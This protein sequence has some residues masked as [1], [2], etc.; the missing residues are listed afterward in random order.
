MNVEFD[1]RSNIKLANSELTVDQTICAPIEGISV[2]ST[3]E[4]TG[5]TSFV[6]EAGICATIPYTEPVVSFAKG[7]QEGQD[8]KEYFR[9]PRLVSSG[10]CSAS[11][12]TLYN[13]NVDRPFLF[14]T[15]FPNGLI[16]L[17]GVAGVRFNLVATVTVAANPFH[18]GL[19][20][21]AF[22]HDGKN[23]DTYQYCRLLSPVL[24]TNLPHVRLDIAE[25]T[26]TQLTVPWLYPEDYMPLTGPEVTELGVF[27]I[28]QVIPTPTLASSPAPTWRLYF[29]LEDLELIG[30]R[31]Q[32]EQLIVAQG[33]SRIQKPSGPKTAIQELKETGLI[34]KTLAGA[35]NVASFVSRHVPMLSTVGGMTSWALSY[36]S[37]AAAAWGFSKPRDRN[38]PIRHFTTDYVGEGNHDIP[39]QAFTISATA[40]NALRIDSTMGGTEVDEMALSHILPRWAQIALT[41]ITTTDTIGTFLYSSNTCLNHY[42]FRTGTTKPFS[43]IAPPFNS[44]TTNCFLPSP[45][46]FFGNFFRMWRGGL[47][48]RFTFGKSKFHAGRVMVGF[49][50]LARIA[51]ADTKNLD[52]VSAIEVT[53]GL[54]QPFSYTKI[55]DLK[56]G[57]S[58]EFEIPYLSP[59]LWTSM[60]GYTGGVTMVVVDTLIA[61]GECATNIP[62]LVE[63][64][65][66]EDFEFAVPR[67]HTMYPVTGNT[68]LTIYTQSGLSVQNTD[69]KEYTVGEAIPSLKQLLMIPTNTNFGLGGGVTWVTN[70]PFFNYYPSFTPNTV[71]MPANLARSL[72]N[73]RSGAL[74]TCY[75]Y[76][77]GGTAYHVYTDD[78]SKVFNI[79]YYVPTDAGFA[80]TSPQNS[81]YTP[82]TYTNS[83]KF[84][85]S[86]NFAHVEAAPYGYY[87]RL[88]NRSFYNRLN[89]EFA[90]NAR[91]LRIS[92]GSLAM[93]RWEA[94]NSTTV[95]TSANIS[96]AAADDARLSTYLGPP[97]VYLFN[98][99]TVLPVI[100]FGLSM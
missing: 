39:S 62:I 57:S 10:T 86:R 92:D 33:G 29:H 54:P 36:A 64:C 53:G 31:P 93:P 83:S 15:V 1:S 51:L 99:L 19:L 97:P 76:W 75:A 72:S 58:F 18:G 82:A 9:R 91:N 84:N 80:S 43:N 13:V 3:P 95:N 45:L 48:Y 42:W 14:N 28:S 34:S 78:G 71:P 98:P 25:S 50:P 61:N 49:S 6:D 38:M 21:S 100:D 60:N 59:Y 27:G 32:V 96:I 85:T 4:I 47:K 16:R 94:R 30:C 12:T 46:M 8:L 90:L 63:V 79:M 40:D 2:N 65:A 5:A 56:D 23:N 66:M 37:G 24:T 77:N 52:Q 73:T 89:G 17:S 68:G 70:M 7:D 26:M 20:A 41:N 67:P 22:Q 74:S 81:I 44:N 35:S 88:S 55:F 87:A 69:V 11:Q